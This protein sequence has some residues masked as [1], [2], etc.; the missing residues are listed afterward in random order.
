[1]NYT[2][3]N[4]DPQSRFDTTHLFSPLKRKLMMMRCIPFP[5][6]V[7]DLREQ[8]FVERWSKST[9]YKAERR[10]KD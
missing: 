5:T 1:M 3:F 2:Y 9:K 8:A 10:K 6:M 7:I 4:R